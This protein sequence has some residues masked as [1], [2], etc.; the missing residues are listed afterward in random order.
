MRECC[1]ES[2][3]DGDNILILCGYNKCETEFCEECRQLVISNN[4]SDCECSDMT[5]IK[6]PDEFSHA[7]NQRYFEEIMSCRNQ[8]KRAIYAAGIKAMDNWY[9]DKGY[10]E[11]SAWAYAIDQVLKAAE[12]WKNNNA[13]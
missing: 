3:E 10:R 4:Y 9:G 6:T 5:P 2:T 11:F 13:L 12:E 1:K 8:N 7:N